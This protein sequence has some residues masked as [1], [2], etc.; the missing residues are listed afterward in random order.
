[1]RNT[2]FTR[3]EKEVSEKGQNGSLQYATC[4]LRN[5]ERND[6]APFFNVLLEER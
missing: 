3:R 4:E 5:D 6:E 2:A 1:M